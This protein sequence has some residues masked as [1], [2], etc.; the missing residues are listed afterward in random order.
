MTHSMPDTYGGNVFFL[1]TAHTK[2]LRIEDIHITTHPSGHS[3]QL[4]NNKAFIIEGHPGQVTGFTT[5]L[6]L[7]TLIMSSIPPTQLLVTQTH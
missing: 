1:Q 6:H 7:S 4:V 2:D 5:L 3:I